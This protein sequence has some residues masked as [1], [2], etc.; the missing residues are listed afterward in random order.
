MPL[1][2]GPTLVQRHRG[3]RKH[4]HLPDVNVDAF[5]VFLAFI[6][7]NTYCLSVTA[8][9]NS[10]PGKF[11]LNLKVYVLADRLLMLD[12]KRKAYDHANSIREKIFPNWVYKQAAKYVYENTPNR[13]SDSAHEETTATTTSEP[14]DKM[15]D[16]VS[17]MCC[18]NLDNLMDDSDFTAVFRSHG[19]LAQ[20]ILLFKMSDEGNY[21]SKH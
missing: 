1:L 6:Y 4:R 14:N 15:R 5:K 21:L 17:K 19:E 11:L 20:D 8:D 16:L 2:R 7:T 3:D 13:Y 10:W 12:L 9:K 18:N